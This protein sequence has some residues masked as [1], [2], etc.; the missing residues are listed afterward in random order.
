MEDFWVDWF[1][2]LKCCE[3]GF[4]LIVKFFS[5]KKSE[6]FSTKTVSA[7][8]EKEICA[9]NELRL[10]IERMQN[11]KQIIEEYLKPLI[12]TDLESQVTI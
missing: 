3:A 2:I 7:E 5:T 4:G 10:A 1:E 9:N 12:N 8:T 11:T 6:G